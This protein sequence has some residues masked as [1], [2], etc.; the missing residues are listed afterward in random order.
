MKEEEII[1]PIPKELLLS[2]LTPEKQL[3]MTNKS[4]NQIFIV[5]AHDS[6]NVMQEIGRLREIAFRT[7][8]VVL[9]RALISMSSTHARIA[10]SSSSCGILTIRK[11]S[12]AT[13]TSWVTNG[14]TMRRDSLSSLQATCSI[15]QR[16]SSRNMLRKPLSLAVHG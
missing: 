16:N 12:A 3:R 9:V 4:N 6:P 10:I 15:S 13:D 1:Q 8:G 5:T 7:A 2:E 14:S 11:S